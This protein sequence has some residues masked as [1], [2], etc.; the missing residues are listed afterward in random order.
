MP[1]IVLSLIPVWLI[2]AL[3]LANVLF[4]VKLFLRW[5]HVVLS[6]YDLLMIAIAFAGMA[7]FDGLLIASGGAACDGGLFCLDVETLVA[8]SRASRLIIIL[9]SLLVSHRAHVR[10]KGVDIIYDEEV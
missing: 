1:A 3:G 9:T 4:L 5:K 10:Q 8:V 2:F 7:F 6:R